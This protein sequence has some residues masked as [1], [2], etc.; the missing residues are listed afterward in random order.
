MKTALALPAKRDRRWELAAQIGVDQAVVHPHMSDGDAGRR[1]DTPWEYDALERMQTE[2]ER[3]G[4]EVGVIE[5][6][7]PLTDT[8]RLGREGRDEEIERFKEFVRTVGALDIPVICYS[9]MTHFWWL[10]TTDTHPIRGGAWTTAYD[11]ERMQRRT[12]DDVPE[13]TERELWE[14]LERFLQRVIPVAEEAGVRLSMHPDDPP[15]SRIHGVTRLMRSVEAYERLL[16]SYPSEANSITFCQGSFAAMGEELP[17]L[18]HR[19]GGDISFVHFRDVRGSSESF[20]ETWQDN[21]PTDMEACIEAY[22]DIGFDGP[23]RPDHVPTTAGE[24]QQ[25][26]GYEMNG[27]LFAIGYMKGLIEAV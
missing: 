13:I 17:P 8:T 11:H 24:K 6:G 23:A 3:T 5:G 20:V 14:N 7:T 16:D 12:R 22:R 1:G 25:T 10:R 19:F 9:W 26:A 4:L 18:I 15:V 27:R 2:F 21:G